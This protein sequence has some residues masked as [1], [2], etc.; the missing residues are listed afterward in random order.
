MLRSL[1]FFLTFFGVIM[2]SFSLSS[3]AFN[4]DSSIPQEYS[5]LGKNI[6]PDLSWENPPEATKS[7]ALTVVDP[8][9]P[10][11]SFTH[12][13][14]YNI[15]ETQK[16]FSKD[17]PIRPKLK[18]GA[19]Q[20]INSYGRIG[21]KGPCPPKQEKHRYFFT[22]YAVDSMLVLPSEASHAELIDALKDHVLAKAELMGYFQKP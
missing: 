21:Y 11:G 19:I 14:V 12:W 1:M 17:T 13:I 9:A 10:N 7:F 8:D 4:Q 22:L 15:P 16:E 5:C 6:S 18:N 20:G 2:G 3:T